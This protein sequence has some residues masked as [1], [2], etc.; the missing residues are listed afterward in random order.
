MTDLLSKEHSILERP[1]MEFRPFGLNAQGEKICDISG[2]VVQSN[3]DYMCD[4]LS[5]TAGEEV[6]T[7]ALDELC[8][9]LNARLPDRSYHVTPDFLRNIWNSY[10]YEFVCYLR[11]FCEQLSG[12]PDFHVN[13]GTHRKVPP[14]IQILC[15]PFST[16][17]LYKMWP[18]LG[19]K[20][21]RNVLEFEVGRVTR[22]SAVLRMTFTDQALA[23]FGPYRKRCVDVICL[24]CKTSIARVQTQLHGIP[25]ATVRDLSC[26]ANGDPYCEWEFTW[27]PQ[28]R[29]SMPLAVWLLVAG[30]TFAYLHLRW[31]TVPTIESL[32]L[33]AI[34]ASLLWWMMTSQMRRAAKPLQRLIQDQEQVVDARHEELREA[35][36][37][38]QSTAVTLR[39]K[40][41]ELTTLHRAGL[42]FSSTFDRDELLTK[43]LDT[44]V[45]DL[46]YDRALI[47]QFDRERRVLHNFRVRGL[48]PEVA[49][50]LRTQE[51]AVTD[52]N[53][54][55]AA[56]LLRGEPVLTNNVQDI[57][58]RLNPFDQQLIKMI[59][60]QSFMTV[61]LKTHHAVLGALSVDR[62]HQHALTQDDLDMLMTL[63]SQ[64]AI[65][66]DNAH[67]Y[68][69]IESLNAGLE[70]RVRER[71]AELEAVNAQLKQMDRLKSKFLAHVS[72]ELRTPLT[73]IVGFADNMLEGLVG[74]LNVK[75]EQYLARI[76]ANG[77]RLAR[78][79]TDLLDLSRVEAGKL[80][81]SFDHIALQTVVSDVIEQLL[82][83]AITK[84][85]Q[86]EIQSPDPTLL[87]WADPDRLSQIL[88]N[89]LD[90]AIK[91]TPDGGHI[92][93]E[94]SVADQEMARIVVRDNGQGIPPDAL[95]KL[96]DPFFRVHHQERSQ[97]KGLGLGLA[98][99]KDLVE[100][101]GG[102]IAVHS[103]LNQG[104]AFT[105]T[106]PL[107]SRA[108]T[109]AGHLP[110]V[111]RRLLVVDDD[112]DICDL[113]RDRLESEGFQVESASDGKTALRVLADTPVD[114]VLL[115]I[116]LPELDG[117]DVLRQL[118]PSHPTLPV[119]M[120]TAVEALDRAMAAVEAGAQGY[121][122]KPFDAS[123]LRHIIDRW[124]QH[125]P[126]HPDSPRGQ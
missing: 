107:H 89:L 125:Q 67:A 62:T 91:Y 96:F 49:E 73:S 53:G 26:T 9:L 77:T 75:Q 123:R 81:L 51:V 23:Q 103:A 78:M 115:D 36:L 7:H 32:G 68:R 63:A 42:L 41:N 2:V 114:G 82:P 13:V 3:V 50:F 72:H 98:I 22:R 19:R 43:V 20:Y 12:D 4:Y 109:P 95:P 105:F 119:V 113:L 59:N 106:I 17:Q 35:Y 126:T 124:F 104:T 55:E 48:P 10:S 29:S 65:A 86:I 44:I 61:P 117:F 121:L 21:V 74:S 79:I 92:S 34:P 46:H 47:A 102:T 111:R 66:L 57:W 93:V 52:P 28:V 58:D 69:Q 97:T 116:A 122:L 33:A 85:L 6:A 60:V 16:P 56:I 80:V 90:N 14:L 64:V 118:R 38:Q 11:E 76:K 100:L 88:T 87:V 25:P 94:L 70:A 108:S 15:R 24:S 99:V 45:H 110:S 37:E 120:M 18:H 39:R 1:F 101:H 84:H 31:P 30:G 54:I 5:R 8:R 27:T 40:V 71:T 112:P 83:L